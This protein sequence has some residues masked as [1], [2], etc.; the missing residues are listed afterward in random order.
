MLYCIQ[1]T[2][3]ACIEYFIPDAHNLFIISYFSW[4][5]V[6]TQ[7]IIS[8]VMFHLEIKSSKTESNNGFMQTFVNLLCTD[9]ANGFVVF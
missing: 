1:I 5:Q 9:Y 3:S 7:M 2:I 6:G 8:V 4:P